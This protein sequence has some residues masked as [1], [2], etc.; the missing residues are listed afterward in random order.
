MTS[1]EAQIQITS[2]MWRIVLNTAKTDA[3]TALFQSPRKTL[4]KDY[5][6]L[7]PSEMPICDALVGGIVAYGLHPRGCEM[8][9]GVVTTSHGNVFNHTYLYNPSTGYIFDP[10]AAQFF[11]P[12]PQNPGRAIYTMMENNPGN[13]IVETNIGLGIL[14][15][16]YCDVGG[17]V[18][19]LC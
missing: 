13:V 18:Y 14:F 8:I 2:P 1:T 17:I 16:P 9:D 15:T 7:W 4:V 12:C 3:L 19:D 6:N 5:R 10:T 11:G